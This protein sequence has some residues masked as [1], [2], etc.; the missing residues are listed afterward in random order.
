MAAPSIAPENVAAYY[1]S[2]AKITVRWTVPSAA[3][4]YTFKQTVSRRVNGG[5][6]VA[7]AS[8]LPSGA[9]VDSY[10]YS[11]TA[12]SA[13]ARFEYRVNFSF[14]TGAAY[15]DGPFSDVTPIVRTTPAAAYSLAGTYDGS[16]VTLTWSVVSPNSGQRASV[17]RRANS[18]AEWS[19]VAAGVTAT[20]WTDSNPPQGAPQYRVRYVCD[21]PTSSST[22]STLVSAW[23]NVA[24][25]SAATLPNAPTVTSPASGQIYNMPT[26]IGVDWVPN[27]P[28]GSEQTS[29]QVRFTIGS[30]SAQTATVSG[31]ATSYNIATASAAANSAVTIQVRT[32]G[33]YSEYGPW[34]AS[35][36]VYIRKAPTVTISSPSSTVS[37]TPIEIRFLYDDVSGEFARASATVRDSA[38]V[39]AYSFSGTWDSEYDS[40]RE[41][42]YYYHTIP[43]TEFLF[44]NGATYTLTVTA[45]ST[46]SLQKNATSTFTTSYTLPNPPTVT[47]A[48]AENADGSAHITATADNEGATVQ[49]VDVRAYRVEGGVNTELERTVD[50]GVYSFTDRL[51]ALDREISYTVVSYSETGVNNRTPVTVT[52][53]SNGKAFF[54]W[55]A[56]DTE[57]LALD[58]DLEW[59]VKVDHNRALYEV[60]GLPDPVLRTTSRRKRTLSASGT[61]WWTGGYNEQ[62]EDLQN[63]PGRVWFREPHGHVTPVAVTV[64]LAYPKGQP[65]TGI[66]VSMTQI[67]ED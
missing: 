15:E 9:G 39:V 50:G 40:Y 10:T 27:H 33:S 45:V 18:S 53:P 38:G 34:S 17:Q 8:D 3:F 36:T 55:G 52:V 25:V 57:S 54:N 26:Q 41:Q 21:T 56:G 60:I 37:V 66:S 58:M 5:Q 59:S 46:S 63:L 23:S 20:T 48:H 11:D 47:D 30:G 44:D 35:T 19:F 29:A 42:T 4:S 7:I 13:N 65:T 1:V 43:V 12:V 61:I 67:T 24:T 51:P 64:G 16:A 2:D 62:F 28:D 49:T 22:T 14:W 31:S 6:W 32:K